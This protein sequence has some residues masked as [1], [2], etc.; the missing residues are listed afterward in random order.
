MLYVFF[1]LKLAGTPSLP[2]LKFK[3][4]KTLRNCDPTPNLGIKP[5]N[6]LNDHQ[7]NNVLVKTSDRKGDCDVHYY[8]SM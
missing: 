7:Q 2:Y 1:Y 4:E 6:R 3:F 8:I 5:F